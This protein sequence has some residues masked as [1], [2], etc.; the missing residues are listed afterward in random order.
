MRQ[1]LL[2][3]VRTLSHLDRKSLSQKVLKLMEEAVDVLLVL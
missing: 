1:D 2:N 3:Y